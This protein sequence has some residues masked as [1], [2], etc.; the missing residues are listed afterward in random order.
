MDPIEELRYRVLAIQRDGNRELGG[1]SA[2]A[3]RHPGAGRGAR[4]L[5]DAGG[6]LT[7]REL[8]EV[9]V[10]EP[11]SPSRLVASLVKAGLV[12]RGSHPDDARASELTLT[13]AGRATAAKVAEVEARLHAALRE[14]LGSHRDRRALRLARR[15]TV[16]T[17]RR[18]RPVPACDKRVWPLPCARAE[19][20]A[21]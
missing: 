13:P 10:C 8:G 19:G 3:R 11:G 1:A 15:L 12:S 6:P 5:A 20:G 21:G 17:A 2:P 4:R 14:R 18:P 7:V 9:L 16:A